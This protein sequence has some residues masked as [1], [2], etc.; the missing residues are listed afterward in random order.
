MSRISYES[1]LDE[2]LRQNPS[3]LIQIQNSKFEER[4]ASTGEVYV[5]FGAGNLGKIALRNLRKAGVEPIAFADNNPGLWNT[6]IENLKVF[7]PEEAAARFVQK[8]V[9]VV[10]VYTGQPV[11][12]QLASLGI[13][14]VSFAALAWR[15]SETFLPYSALELPHKI[16]NQAESIRKAF[17]LWSDDASKAEYLAQLKW[18]TTLDWSVLPP[19]L[20]QTEIYFPDNTIASY[21]GEVFVD[22]GS[23]DGDTIREFIKRRNTSFKKIIAFEPDPLNFQAL[24]L[25]ISSLPNEMRSKIFP[26]QSAVGSRRQMMRFDA[27]G[28][29]GSSIGIGSL[30]VPG[31]ALDELV[32]E[33]SPTY[34]K[35]DIEGAEPD[36]I[37]GTRQIIQKDKPVLAICLY[38]RQ[39]HLWQIPLRI[40]LLS[41]QY[42]FYL[43]RYSDEC[44]ELVSYAVPANR[45][46][47]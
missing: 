29:V 43:R 45:L 38:H 19:H 34:I 15:Y 42:N 27:T 26:I 16:F 10:T 40:K 32:A 20:P 25:Y 17:S 28:T 8:A 22:C 12:R 24:N 44:W 1:Q 46:K 47:R 23:F 39:E 31:A 11:W 3:D 14:P 35:M 13:K 41:D 2:I 7:S 33:Y 4:I 9:F 36:A 37:T 18:R 5:L 6:T 21:S 30:D